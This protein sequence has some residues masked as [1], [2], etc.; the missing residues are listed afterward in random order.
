MDPA[1]EPVDEEGNPGRDAWVLPDEMGAIYREAQCAVCHG[2][3]S[4][5]LA[6]LGSSLLG[7]LEGR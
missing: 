5:G 6:S 1:G 2:R 4:R 3:E 7:E